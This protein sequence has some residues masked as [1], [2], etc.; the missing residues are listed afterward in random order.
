M[1]AL[2]GNL[3]EEKMQLSDSDVAR[4]LGTY[5]DVHGR[6]TWRTGV[7][8]D[9]TTEMLDAGIAALEGHSLGSPLNV[10]AVA[11]YRAM[12]SARD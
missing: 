5:E 7:D 6:P 8:I 10:V 3:A 2:L 9:I 12:A 4:Q 11:V 1:S